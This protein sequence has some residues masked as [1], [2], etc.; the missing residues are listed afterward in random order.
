MTTK[1][2]TT[3]TS[4]KAAE[5]LAMASIEAPATTTHAAIEQTMRLIAGVYGPLFQPPPNIVLA[6]LVVLRDTTPEEIA[7]AVDEHLR[8]TSVHNGRARNEYCPSAPEIYSR[9]HAGR[10]RRTRIE[11][12]RQEYDDACLRWARNPEVAH[13]EAATCRNADGSRLSG[14]EFEQRLAHGAAVARARGEDLPTQR[15]P[16]S[17]DVGTGLP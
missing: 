4:M 3:T 17:S 1:S 16:S 10:G 2:L 8:D 5:L 15:T 6:W 7:A 13:R 12:M 14:E 11:R 9:I